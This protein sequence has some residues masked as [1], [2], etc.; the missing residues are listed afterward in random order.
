MFLNSPALGS[1]RR[2]PIHRSQ[3][4]DLDVL[5]R[6]RPMAGNLVHLMPYLPKPC[7][8]LLPDKISDECVRE[9]F[10][11]AQEARM[12]FCKTFERKIWAYVRHDQ[13]GIVRDEQKRLQRDRRRDER[14][15]WK[16]NDGRDREDVEDILG[17]VAVGLRGV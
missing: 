12:S 3:M 7:C 2:V 11:E 8:Q 5:H 15:R 4:I 16:M 17:S 9:M 1:V 10:N 6:P 13:L 14:W